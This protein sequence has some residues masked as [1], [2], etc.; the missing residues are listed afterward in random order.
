MRK[1]WN[2]INLCVWL[3]IVLIHLF[4][5]CVV[6]CCWVCRTLLHLPSI[7]ALA[8]KCW[9]CRCCGYFLVVGILAVVEHMWV[10]CIRLCQLLFCSFACGSAIRTDECV[11]ERRREQVK[12]RD[13]NMLRNHESFVAWSFGIVSHSRP[14]ISAIINVE[15]IKWLWVECNLLVCVCV[16][17]CVSVGCVAPYSIYV[18]WSCT[19][20]RQQGK[21]IFCCIREGE[22]I[23]W[24]FSQLSFWSGNCVRQ[25]NLY[26][27]V[28][29]VGVSE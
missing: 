20:R 11:C 22:G 25:P 12:D 16:S 18:A 17:V 9:C 13:G 1:L 2:L 10:Q 27:N 14:N 6:L 3:Q 21:Q 29:I 5:V 8:I 23:V 28:S 19:G 26:E 7:F 4:F 24:K 15:E